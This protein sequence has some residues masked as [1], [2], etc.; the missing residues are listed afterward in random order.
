MII[1]LSPEIKNKLLFSENKQLSVEI[2][3]FRLNHLLSKYAIEHK[4]L[5]LEILRE[6]CD[7]KNAKFTDD[8]DIEIEE[9]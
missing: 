6:H 1:S 4:Q 2:E 3:I 5:M 8:L 7:N 9:K